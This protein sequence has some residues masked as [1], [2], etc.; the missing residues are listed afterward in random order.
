MWS[1]CLKTLISTVLPVESQ[2]VIFWGPEYVALYN[3]AY[4]PTI[5]DKHPS[6][7]GRPAIE[8][9]LELWDDLEPLLRGV[10]ETGKT[11]SA[12]DRP[13]YIERHGRG[14]H[15]NF[16]ISYSA[17]PEADGSVGG[18]LCIV[19]ETTERVQYEHLQA[20]LLALGRAMPGSNDPE[21]IVSRLFNCLTAEI[22]PS[23]M[24]IAEKQQA[25]AAEFGILQAYGYES[26]GAIPAEISL[27]P[28]SLEAL[29][30]GDAVIFGQGKDPRFEGIH[31]TA[32]DETG[33]N[34]RLYIPLFNQCELS[35]IFCLEA[36]RGGVL[37][38]HAVTIAMEA[39]KLAWTWVIHARAEMASRRSSAQISAMFD[40]AKVGI[41]I[42]SPTGVFERVNERYC[43]LVG[44][45]RHELLG[46]N[47]SSLFYGI[48][49]G[50]DT[51]L[52]RRS[53]GSFVSC[54][55]EPGVSPTWVQHHL[56]TFNESDGSHSGTLCVSM[57][58]T[59]RIKAE[60]DLRALNSSLE[61]RVAEMVNQREEAVAQ[62]H[63]A[64]KMEMVGQL[65]GGIAHDFNNLLT[66]IIASME[67]LQ[68]QPN[69]AKTPVL[70]DAALQAAERA[71]LL[72]S[73]LLSFARRQTLKPE[74]V[75]LPAL[76]DDMRDLL[77][78]SLTPLHQVVIEI[79]SKLPSVLVDPRQ[80]ELSIL[81][82]AVNARDA[83]EEGG[84]LEISAF[85]ER[86]SE[87]ALLQQTAG[88]YI[89]LQV[90]DF[91]HGMSDDVLKRCVEPFFSTKAIGKGTGLGLSMVQGLALQSKGRFSIS[92][93]EGCGTVVSL[94]LP[95]AGSEP[96]QSTNFEPADLPLAPFAARVLLVDD[97]DAV[98]FTTAL[99]LRELGYEVVEA[100]SGEAA[101]K[102]VENG[103]TPHLLISDQMMPSKTGIE[104]SQELRAKLPSLPVLII[105]GYTN[106][107]QEHFGDVKVLP[108]PFHHQ[109]LASTA[110]QMLKAS[111]E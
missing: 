10:R 48:E 14:E 21:A 18:V 61:A 4:A 69:R 37:S 96:K 106:L 94:W 12:K 15:V 91:G 102:A 47:R 57:D 109:D 20:V 98:R 86:L 65:S 83:M 87:D 39:A 88:D 64:R 44:R 73:K 46:V 59:D 90:R 78:R 95:I 43:H 19:T 92:S 36:N 24:L 74:V 89:C 70:I 54:L 52:P 35:V 42:C 68:R 60:E 76:L 63:E 25:S 111:K 93:E 101:L 99:L 67:L 82:L 45:S 32:A 8:Y 100:N 53:S 7:L 72:V 51:S 107:S 17:V 84:R 104:L 27:A 97:D 28:E 6:A 66:P 103:F 22:S 110:A 85:L 55:N 79:D 41:A 29:A 38:R 49:K 81:N 71:R 3:D 31:W 9:W 1:P 105:T 13:F 58:V 5:G 16:D 30:R 26:A 2:I 108:K 80:L 40:Q 33:A 62:L 56:T 77:Q 11:F 23:R 50:S 75:D 34:E